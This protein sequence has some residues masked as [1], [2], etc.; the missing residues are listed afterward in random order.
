MRLDRGLRTNFKGKRGTATQGPRFVTTPARPKPFEVTSMAEIWDELM[1]QIELCK[2][3]V[4]GSSDAR[5][6]EAL[7]IEIFAL[8]TRRAE[9]EK[10][11]VA[12]Q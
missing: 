11:E 9:L 7:L 12:R 4:K 10:R 8:E 6:R 1:G 5:M 2:R 3:L